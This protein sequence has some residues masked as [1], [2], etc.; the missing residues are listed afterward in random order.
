[1]RAKIENG[2][3]EKV[4]IEFGEGEISIREKNGELLITEVSGRRL[5]LSPLGSNAISIETKW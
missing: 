2:M 4:T 3:S 1:M 5:K